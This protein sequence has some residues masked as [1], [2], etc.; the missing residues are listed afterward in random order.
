MYSIGSLR[1]PL[2]YISLLQ[3]CFR[4]LTGPVSSHDEELDRETRGEIHADISWL[5][6]SYFS[7]AY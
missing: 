2:G 1:K 4:L 6:Y 5:G 7:V 3:Q